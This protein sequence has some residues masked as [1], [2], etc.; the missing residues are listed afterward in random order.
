MNQIARCG[1]TKIIREFD[2][3]LAL[4]K[5]QIINR[6]YFTTVRKY[7][8][9]FQVVKLR[10]QLSKMLHEKLKFISSSHHVIFFLLYR[11]NDCLHANNHEK[12]GSE[13]INIFTSEDMENMHLG[14]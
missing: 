11:Q 12:A 7:I 3:V 9:Y 4:F 8:F 1:M 10:Q 14:P 5:L 2:C 13:V 6:G